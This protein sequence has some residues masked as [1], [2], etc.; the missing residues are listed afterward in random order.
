MY[1]VHIVK[2]PTEACELLYGGAHEH[3]FPWL[4]LPVP[5]PDGETYATWKHISKGHKK[6]PCFYWALSSTNH[7]RWLLNHAIEICDEYTIRYGKVHKTEWHL[8]FILEHM[9]SEPTKQ[10]TPM[11]TKDGFRDFLCDRIQDDETKVDDLMSKI[12]TVNPPDGCL[13]GILA[14]DAS[15]AVNTKSGIDLVA[16]YVKYYDSKRDTF[17]KPALHCKRKREAYV[18]DPAA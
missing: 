5:G 4:Q 12:C 1:D 7:A 18:F 16:S 14:A 17:K 9:F 6:H 3:N 15:F 10:D 11:L 13:F 2:M 8:K